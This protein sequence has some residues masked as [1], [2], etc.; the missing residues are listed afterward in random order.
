VLLFSQLDHDVEVALSHLSPEDCQQWGTLTCFSR[1]LGV[2]FN[3]GILDNNAIM[4]DLGGPASLGE[5]TVSG[6]VFPE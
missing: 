3:Q 5:R 1:D 4:V 2:S 6:F